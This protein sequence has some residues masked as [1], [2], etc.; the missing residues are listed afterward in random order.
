MYAHKKIL[1]LV[2]EL[3]L[4]QNI[5]TIYLYFGQITIFHIFFKEHLFGKHVSS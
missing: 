2:A 3:E 5:W 4:N 1:H